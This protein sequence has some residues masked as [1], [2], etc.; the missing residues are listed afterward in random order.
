M[1]GVMDT[2]QIKEPSVAGLLLAK[3]N[4]ALEKKI[5]FTLDEASYLQ[6]L[7]AD[8]RVDEFISIVGNLIEN[9]LDELAGREDSEIYI[10]IFGSDFGVHIAVEDNGRGI[11][12]SMQEALFTRGS[13]SKGADRGFGLSTVQRI[14]TAFEGTIEYEGQNG[15][16]FSI[17]IP[18]RK[19]NENADI[20]RRG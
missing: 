1:V 13:S 11:P 19:E 8:M 6:E 12:S 4:K 18:I 14:V 5:R 16:S 17:W 10:G 7:P 20:D 9:A 2:Q 15:A 3:Y